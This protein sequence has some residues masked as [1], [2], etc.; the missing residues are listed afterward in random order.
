MSTDAFDPVKWYASYPGKVIRRPGYPARAAFKSTLM[1]SLYGRRVLSE[2][3]EVGSYADIGGCF[4]FGANSM[5]FHIS[6]RQTTEPH[7]VVFEI[8]PDFVTMGQMLFPHITFIEGQFSQSH[9]A[10][11][12]FDLVTMFDVLEHVV[13]PGALLEEVAA[14]SRYTMLMTPMETSGEW[15]GNRPPASQGAAHHDG[16]INFFYP[17]AYETLLRSSGLDILESSVIR[18]VMPFNAWLALCPEDRKP[19]SLLDKLR[20][21]KKLMRMLAEPGRLLRQ[22]LECPC[23]PFPLARR[24][25]GGGYHVCLCKSRLLA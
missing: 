13:D 5:A 16:H 23:I 11:S 19:L 3:K 9:G 7:T 1:F 10:P 6:Q 2:I 18:R 24:L 12:P 14:R 20:R 25:V 15:R 8:S 22:L 4:G 17:A 21:P